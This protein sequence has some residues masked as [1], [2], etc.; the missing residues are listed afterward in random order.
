MG[1]S[2]F[3]SVRNMA[4]AMIAAAVPL[5]L[6]CQMLFDRIRSRSGQHTA[7]STSDVLRPAAQIF[8]VS[9]AL[10]LAV[11]TGLFSQRMLSASP[12]PLGALAFM[13]RHD[14]HGNVL[15]NF[16][17]GE[18]MIFH[19]AD[20]RV[21]IDGRYQLVYPPKVIEDYIAFQRGL[22][23]AADMLE[24]YQHDYVLISPDSDSYK[25]MC[26]HKDWKLI[27]S[28]STSVLFA[29]AQSRAADI[30]GIPVAGVAPT[31]YFP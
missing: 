11:Q 22:P 6:H 19:D 27:Y 8:I 5:A 30:P 23:G 2:P 14:L 26:S 9:L 17:W 3:V 1:I 24:S 21:F 16:G 4:L 7:K 29:R 31:S 25:L 28:D 10:L 20:S 18:F 15:C 12:S 13:Q